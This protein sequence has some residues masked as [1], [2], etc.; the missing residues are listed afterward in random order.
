MAVHNKTLDEKIIN[1][2]ELFYFVD[3][4]PEAAEKIGYSDYSYWKSVFQ[5]F[6][7]KKSAVIL[8]FVFLA[9]VIFSFIAL[10]IGKYDYASLVPDTTKGFISPNS[11]Y[12]FGT[13]NL[14]RDYWS[15]VWYA[16]QISIKLALIVGLGE[17]IVGVIIGCLWGYVR[18]L[19][20]FFTELYNLIYNVPSIIYLTLIALVVGQ[21][22]WIMAISLIAFGWL[23]MA[24]NVRN[25]VMIHRDREYNL[26]S[27][28]LGT[29]TW[30]ILLKN[31]LPQLVSVIIL[32]LA[33]SIPS[34]IATES[35]LS[36]LG[37]GLD[38][39]TP[40][41]GILLRNARTFFLDYPYL[42]IFPAVI[43]SIISITFYLLGNAFSDAS[44]PRNHV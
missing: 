22:F 39:N 35:M 7:K 36:Y 31:I 30:R 12:W 6:L 24:R 42:L 37:L 32:R 40:S 9:L 13:D 15:Q 16:S 26:A 23:V 17:C 20:R 43:V 14:G 19:D 25:L 5:N 3:Y 18:K 1:E 34:T 28:S 33:L 10:K 4:S 29:P 38:I 27:R 8:S 21:S 11:E 2:D 44:D 41:L